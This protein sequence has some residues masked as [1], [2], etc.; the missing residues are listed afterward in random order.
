MTGFPSLQEL[1]SAE[2]A[3][4]EDA[5]ASRYTPERVIA[6]ADD[7]DRDAKIAAVA[8]RYPGKIVIVRTLVGSRMCHAAVPEPLEGAGTSLPA[9][10]IDDDV[11][12]R[13]RDRIA[14]LR[15]DF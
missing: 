5:N 12:E 1:V 8:A 15:G 9:A 13:A 11:I 10:R 7:P 2:L 6:H 3:R 14:K 4:R